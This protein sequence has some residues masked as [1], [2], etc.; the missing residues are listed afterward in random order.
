MVLTF[1]QE[2]AA[3]ESKCQNRNTSSPMAPETKEK[4]RENEFAP[5]PR[6]GE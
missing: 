3:Q 2:F 5:L 6:T 1:A 4:R